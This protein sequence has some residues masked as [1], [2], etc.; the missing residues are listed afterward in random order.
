MSPE[1]S[2]TYRHVLLRS[3]QGKQ[4]DVYLSC[5]AGAPPEKIKA[6]DIRYTAAP[7][8]LSRERG[9]EAENVPRMTLFHRCD[10]NK[11]AGARSITFQYSS[12]SSRELYS[13]RSRRSTT[14]FG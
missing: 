13:G 7:T 1:T 14:A 9:G 3:Y 12:L 11:T 5:R 10:I 2:R 6:G 8:F 4:S